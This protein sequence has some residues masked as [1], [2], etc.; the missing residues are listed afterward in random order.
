MEKEEI[1]QLANYKIEL[2][3]THEKSQESF[4]KQLSYISA[5]ALGLSMVFIEKVVKNV[6]QACYKWVLILSWIFLGLTLVVNLI[7]HLLAAKYAYRT[8]DDIEHGL[9]DYDK[10]AKRNKFIILLNAFSVIS[11][12]IGILSLI[13]FVTINLLS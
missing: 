6:N 11:L 3:K 10:A 9:Y 1:E 12:L 7:S 5:G 13:L 8:M 4:E 2:L